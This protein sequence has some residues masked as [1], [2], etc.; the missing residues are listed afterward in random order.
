MKLVY[1][2][3]ILK[4]IL[5]EYFFIKKLIVNYDIHKCKIFYFIKS[6]IFIYID[7]VNF[8][9]IIHKSRSIM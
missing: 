9:Y 7:N 2:V 8:F 4:I 5:K 1:V 6:L 3:I